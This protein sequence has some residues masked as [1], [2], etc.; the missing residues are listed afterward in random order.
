MNIFALFLS[1]QVITKI[2]IKRII[3]SHHD[4]SRQFDTVHRLTPPII[5]IFPAFPP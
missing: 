3:Q 2:K 4:S 1:Q 5:F